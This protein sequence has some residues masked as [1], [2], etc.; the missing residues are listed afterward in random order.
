MPRTIPDNE[1]NQ[2]IAFDKVNSQQIY[3]ESLP[4]ARHEG[5]YHERKNFSLYGACILLRDIGS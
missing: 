1:Y 4:S 5:S 3:V 2:E